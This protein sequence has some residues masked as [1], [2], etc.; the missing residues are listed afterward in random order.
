MHVLAMNSISFCHPPGPTTH[1]SVQ[2]ALCWEAGALQAL[3][4]PSKPHPWPCRWPK[5]E[6]GF[7]FQPD[8]AGLLLG[9]GWLKLLNG[10]ALTEEGN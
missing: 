8:P 4:A 7:G 2:A 3:L 10:A 1:I 9:F 5:P 6:F